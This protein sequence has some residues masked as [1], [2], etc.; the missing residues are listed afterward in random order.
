[1]HVSL[2]MSCIYWGFGLVLTTLNAVVFTQPLAAMARAVEEFGNENFEA[3]VTVQSDDMIGRLQ[4]A[5]NHMGSEMRDKRL[6]KT[7]FGHYVSPAIRDLILDGRVNTAGDRIEAVI[8]FT[9]IRS[10]T[11]LSEA[12]P[13][14]KVIQLLNLHFS[15]VVDTVSEN[16]GFVDKFIGD[17]VMAVFDSEFCSGMHRLCALKAAAEILGGV[18]QTNLE[19]E[20]IGF[21]PISIG[22]GIACGDVIRGNVGSASR[23]ELTVIGD[24]VNTASRLESATR[25]LGLPLLITENSYDHRC[26]ELQSLRIEQRTS[27]R[28]R[29]KEDAVSVI[30]LVLSGQP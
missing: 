19:S 16:F 20:A 26:A 24:T 17:A 22:V 18:A 10:F 13:P 12:H 30:G 28:L 1:L 9:D 6:I 23:R 7:L 14:E 29:G 2:A 5:V 4:G 21:G 15:R 25:E 3:R 8:L 11:A 27:L